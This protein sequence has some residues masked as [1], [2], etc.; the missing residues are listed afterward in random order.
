MGVFIWLG[1]KASPNKRLGGDCVLSH[2]GDMGLGVWMLQPDNVDYQINSPNSYYLYVSTPFSDQ[3]SIFLY[4]V[5]SQLDPVTC[6]GDTLAIVTAAFP[7]P[8]LSSQAQSKS[9][10]HSDL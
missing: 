8:E 9:P 3:Q 10:I 2:D 6:F 7:I 5:I 4:S 1:K